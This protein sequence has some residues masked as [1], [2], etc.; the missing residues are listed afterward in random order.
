VTFFVVAFQKDGLTNVLLL[1]RVVGMVHLSVQSTGQDSVIAASTN[2]AITC[3]DLAKNTELQTWNT[4]TRPVACL[5]WSPLT[6]GRL[7]S[8]TSDPAI[9][10][11]DLRSAKPTVTL[12][13]PS[14]AAQVQ[15]SPSRRLF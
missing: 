2:T 5:H 11:H 6:T 7:V 12:K 15:W 13:G 8:A 9:L 3:W 4:H 14:G 10:V 1:Q